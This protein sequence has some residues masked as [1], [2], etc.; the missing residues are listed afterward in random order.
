LFR[1]QRG[2]VQSD[3]K[4]VFDGADHL[5]YTE[6]ID[7]PAKKEVEA[8]WDFDW[9]QSHCFNRF[10]VFRK[11]KLAH[12]FRTIVAHNMLGLAGRDRARPITV[13]AKNSTKRRSNGLLSFV[14]FSASTKQR[15]ALSIPGEANEMFMHGVWR[16]LRRAMASKPPLHSGENG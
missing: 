7:Y 9:I 14:G 12:F 10:R 16:L 3:A 2:Q 4:F 6:G 5:Q 8:G 1:I 15:R 13:V 11:Q